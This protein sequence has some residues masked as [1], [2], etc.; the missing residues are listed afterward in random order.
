MKN[1]EQSPKSAE[2]M[3][4]CSERCCLRILMILVILLAVLTPGAGRAQDATPAT[5]DAAVATAWS[6]LLL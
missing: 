1:K 2:A 4:H 6:D 3:V 5:L